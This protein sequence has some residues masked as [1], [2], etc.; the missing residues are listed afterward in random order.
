MAETKEVKKPARELSKFEKHVIMR[1][2][3]YIRYVDVLE[4]TLDD[5]KLY[6]FADVDKELEKALKKEAK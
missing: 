4:I 1:A 5:D 2:K 3:K 6:S